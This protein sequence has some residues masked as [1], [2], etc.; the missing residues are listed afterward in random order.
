MEPGARESVSAVG[1]ELLC[2]VAR[3]KWQV[4]GLE[5][6]FFNIR[7]AGRWTAYPA[8]WT[9][10]VS[11]LRAA[12]SLCAHARRRQLRATSSFATPSKR[13]IRSRK[14]PGAMTRRFRNLHGSMIFPTRTASSPRRN[15]AHPRACQRSQSLLRH[16]HRQ[17]R[18]YAFGN[19]AALLH[20]GS[21]TGA[22]EQQ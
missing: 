5:V 17:A 20:H 22:A 9:A 12:R 18:R 16:V 7:T 2:A 6:G 1:G 11:Q 13:A 3:G 19:R 8:M 15:A 21:R 10:T 14:S 4:A